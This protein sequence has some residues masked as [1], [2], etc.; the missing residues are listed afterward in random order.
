MKQAE[1]VHE[2]HGL[3]T[4]ESNWSGLFAMSILS[5]VPIFVIFLFFQRYLIEGIATTGMKR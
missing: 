3:S 2:L 4:A 1:P 5:L